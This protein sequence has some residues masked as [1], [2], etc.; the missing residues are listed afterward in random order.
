MST[1]GLVV[2]RNPV[3]GPDVAWYRIS[4]IVGGSVYLKDGT[5]G[6]AEGEVIKASDAEADG[7]DE[8]DIQTSS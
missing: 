7:A 4:G 5:T 2:A 8:F 3:D 6:V 1:T